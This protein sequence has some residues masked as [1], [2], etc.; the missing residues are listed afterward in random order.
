VTRDRSKAVR[1]LEY[2]KREIS[3]QA[4]LFAGMSQV[5]QVHLGGARRR[6]FRLPETG[7]S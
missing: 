3:M 5:E 2:L 7:R 4:K 1:Y 6:I